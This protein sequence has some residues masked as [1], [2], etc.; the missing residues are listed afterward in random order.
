[1][2]FKKY[3]KMIDAALDTYLPGAGAYPE[4]IH[5][6]MRYSVFSGGKRIRPVI[7]MESARACG[8]TAA[9]ALPCACAIELVHTYS[10]IHDD[11]PS[12]DDDDYRRGKKTC[13]KV[14]GEA[15]AI[16]A[17]DALLTLAF[18][19]IARHMKPV[20]ARFAAIELSDAIGT[21][22]MVGGQAADIGYAR[23]KKT[24]E[25]LETINRLKTGR[26]FEASA[27]MGAIAAGANERKVRAI[28][29]YGASIG[30]AFQIVDDIL[31]DDGYA[32]LA[33]HRTSCEDARG[34]ITDAQKKLKIFGNKADG[35][36]EIADTILERIK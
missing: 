31:D 6:A 28:A 1:M 20:P 34:L 16:L 5:K 32:A 4:I 10:L 3:I 23:K 12:M 27:K 2:D 7:V 35:L 30:R 11:L 15:N 33:G 25:A 22:G 14:F 24:I 21:Y 29:R 18:N 8:A 9:Q 19:V 13:H 17:G 36:R 26:L